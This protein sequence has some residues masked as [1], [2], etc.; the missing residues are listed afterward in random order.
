MK[1]FWKKIWVLGSLLVLAF[2]VQAQSVPKGITYQ[3]V[4][5][6]TEGKQMPGYD[7]TGQPI[8]NKLINIRFE[9]L[10]GSEDGDIHYAETHQTETDQ[11]GQFTV[12]IGQGT[13]IAAEV[14]SFNHV[15]WGVHDFF[16]KV[17][18]D[19]DDN[20]EFVHLYTQQLMA[21]P[22]SFYAEQAGNGIQ[23]IETD[24]NGDHILTYYNGWVVKVA[25]AD[26]Q[27]IALQ[28]DSLLIENGNSLFL[29]DIDS[30]NEV[31]LLSFANDTLFISKANQVYLGI[32]R[33][34]VEDLGKK[35]QADSAFQHDLT[36]S[37]AAKMLRDSMYFYALNRALVAK[38]K[39]DSS[40]F[41]QEHSN[42]LNKLKTDSQ[43]FETQHQM[44]ENKRVADSVEFAFKLKGAE[45]RISADS[46]HFE[47]RMFNLTNSLNADSVHF[48]AWLSSLT[49]KVISD[50][51][52]FSSE[53]TW[54]SNRIS[55]DSTLMRTL[56]QQNLSRIL[57]DSQL[58]HQLIIQN[59]QNIQSDS[60]HYQQWLSTLQS[61]VYTDSVLL[62]T[63]ESQILK[64][65]VDDSTALSQT[66][67]NVIVN[68]SSDS[69][70][71]QNIATRHQKTIDSLATELAKDGDKSAT[72][73]IQ[74]LS[75]T[76]DNI[77]LSQNG[78]T[79]S[80]KEYRDSLNAHNSRLTTVHRQRKADSLHFE[81]KFKTANDSIASHNTRLQ[82]LD[83]RLDD[84]LSIHNFKLKTL[85][86]K[87]ASD[88]AYFEGEIAKDGDKSATNEIQT[89]SKT[90]DNISLSNSG[91]SVSLKEY[92][93]SLNAHNTRLRVQNSKFKDSL[94]VHNFK[95]ETLNSKLKS[96]STHF[97]GKL[98][99]DNDTSATNELQSLLLSGDTLFLSNSNHVILSGLGQG[100][101]AGIDS[102]ATVIVNPGDTIISNGFSIVGIE[103]TQIYLRS[104]WIT[105][106]G[107][108]TYYPYSTLNIENGFRLR[109][110]GLW[111]C[112]EN[113][114]RVFTPQSW[115][116]SKL[117]SEFNLNVEEGQDGHFATSSVWMSNVNGDQ[118]AFSRLNLKVDSNENIIVS[119]YLS[120]FQTYNIE[121][122]RFSL[123]V[124]Y[125]AS[126]STNGNSS[127]NS[128][129][130]QQLSLNG[131][132]L[133]LTNGGSVTLPAGNTSDT[134][135]N[136]EIQTLSKTGDNISLSNNGGIVSLKEYSDSIAAHNT[137]LQTLDSR[138]I[139][140]LRV[141]NFK[142]ETLNSKLESDSIHF[143]NKL[144]YD[145]DKSATNELQALSISNDTIFLSNGGFV[146]LPASSTGGVQT[147]IQDT[148]GD[149]KIETEKSADIDEISLTLGGIERFKF[150]SNRLEF[151]N[152]GNSIFI[153][154]KAGKNDDL[155]TNNNIFIGSLSGLNNTIGSENI[156]MGYAT[157]Y[158][159]LN[160][161]N[162][163]FIG[164]GAGSLNRSG[165]ENS[166]FGYASGYHNYSGNN[167][168][169][170][171]AG[172][173]AYNRLGSNNV[174]I[175][176]LAGANSL[177]HSKSGVVHIGSFAGYQDTTDNKLY[178][179]NDSSLNPLIY[180]EFD[181]RL[182]NIGGQ[183]KI[184][185]NYTLPKIDGT[186]GQV[187]STNGNGSVSWTTPS[188]G[189]SSSNSDTA[190]YV[191]FSAT[192]TNGSANA[193][194][195]VVT[196]DANSQGLGAPLYITS[197]G[198]YKTTDADDGTTMPCVALALETG[199]GS[200]RVIFYGFI[201]NNNWNWTVG[202][203]IYVHTNTGEMTQT[204]PSGT[205]DYVQVVGFA[206][207]AKTMMFNPDMT[208]IKLK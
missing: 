142:L 154:D 168:T 145:G 139:D 85:N 88:S 122:Q 41:A 75:K 36:N 32:Y 198:T 62:R 118:Y 111:F 169:A 7:M 67:N 101:M 80:L 10:K 196:V 72:N 146:K 13:P 40:H 89:L 131:N 134:S 22:Y 167:N 28:G 64:K 208:L 109:N 61:R 121:I 156:F 98:A 197:T 191:N 90:G 99:L 128:S 82:T 21:V 112:P 108:Q 3:A 185:N 140:S 73:E 194:S 17:Y 158:Y 81:S 79:V 159:N 92:R 144:S 24:A 15:E 39:A 132:T 37:L 23:K 157:G 178:I 12:V 95:L 76:G 83:S 206:T 60:V 203:R 193:V 164:N 66:I 1:L 5:I 70:Y 160:G 49:N 102:V 55:T 192:P 65:V 182:L 177:V 113:P 188:G 4:A 127:S 47:T 74:T 165:I 189:S 123:R 205:A 78:G 86:S 42:T 48:S 143:E 59:Q 11:Y 136:N 58:F 187:L 46:Q 71:F 30:T 152:S 31:Q 115:G 93:D 69:I 161:K 45:N 106:G 170:L 150:D 44:H 176:H 126:S 116:N 119:T 57:V 54:L 50:S 16:I 135:A 179:H 141:H 173:G 53:V 202:Q 56:V 207:A 129:T 84:S 204:P 110:N 96:D 34:L 68:Q 200:K 155:T 120:G 104:K 38:V 181:N 124:Y 14:D 117:T 29:P 151:L 190:N 51:T 201:T 94:S 147:K 87:L 103:L 195:S 77:S 35:V 133:S 43:Y 107:T 186:N 8:P 148:D 105:N 162:N 183:L 125:T 137:R 27:S 175:G 171:G 52:F 174:T 130:Y 6:D 33:D 19:I 20:Q 138:L 184:N 25:G 163:S 153:G 100:R 166:F 199:T 26:N 9:I 63:I 91:G 97:E 149:T 180:G 2:G 18:L 172:S 114:S